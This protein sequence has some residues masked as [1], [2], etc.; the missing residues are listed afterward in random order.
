MNK[1]QKM[2]AEE[3]CGLR[4]SDK[5][6]NRLLL[7][8]KS[9]WE[10]NNVFQSSHAQMQLLGWFQCSSKISRFHGSVT[11]P[12]SLS[13]LLA[14][15]LFLYLAALLT[16]T[17]RRCQRVVRERASL[18]SHSAGEKTKQKKN[19]KETNSHAGVQQSPSL[20]VFIQIWTHYQQHI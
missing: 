4:T 8:L 2:R 5:T 12:L 15:F 16:E 13:R 6:R 19:E 14:L 3:R 7:P 18:W 20:P 1:T 9:Y 17:Q 10:M 11:D